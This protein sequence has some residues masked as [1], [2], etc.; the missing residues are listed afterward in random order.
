MLKQEERAIL[1]DIEAILYK[2]EL[3]RAAGCEKVNAVGY[4]EQASTK[5]APRSV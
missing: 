2:L 5:P 1:R 4:A 3:A